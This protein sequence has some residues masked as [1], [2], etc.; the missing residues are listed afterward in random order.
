MLSLNTISFSIYKS[1][2]CIILSTYIATF[3]QTSPQ[4][5]ICVSSH[6]CTTICK[7]YLLRLQLFILPQCTLP[8][9]YIPWTL[10]LN[11]LQGCKYA[12]WC[13]SCNYMMQ[14]G[15]GALDIATLYTL[16]LPCILLLNCLHLFHH[17]LTRC[18]IPHVT[19]SQHYVSCTMW[20]RLV[21]YLLPFSFSYFSLLLILVNNRRSTFAFGVFIRREI[22]QCKVTGSVLARSVSNLCEEALSCKLLSHLLPWIQPHQESSPSPESATVACK[23]KWHSGW[24]NE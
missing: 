17:L 19:I 23:R 16:G 11:Y 18:M 9:I 20:V 12:T 2:Y 1:W 4:C 3:I 10:L 6:F 15:L 22:R 5:Y 24:F 8:F 13:H 14:T 7:F 21:H